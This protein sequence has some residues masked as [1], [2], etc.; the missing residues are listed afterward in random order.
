[1]HAA[2]LL[3]MLSLSAVSTTTD[4]LDAQPGR[5]IP[6]TLTVPSQDGDTAHDNT[7]PYLLFVPKQYE[8]STDSF[9]LLLFLHG[10]GESGHGGGELDRVKANGPPKLVDSRPNFPFILVSPQCAPVEESEEETAWKPA[11]LIQLIDHVAKH[12]RV[13]PAGIYVTGLSM[14]GFGVWQLAAAY[15]DRI[16]AAVPICGGGDPQTM[17]KPLTKVP[18]WCFHGAKDDLV[19]PTRDQAMVDAVK[20]AGGDVHLTLYP[21]ANHNA[22]SATYDNQAVYDWLLSHRK[23]QPGEPASAGGH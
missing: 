16:A 5:Q 13:D 4:A 11:Q 9:P 10:S 12:L 23:T 15:P 19:P 17:A 2:L 7:I 20:A 21:S 1:M 22:W 8:G 18:I 14:G 3:T 6:Q